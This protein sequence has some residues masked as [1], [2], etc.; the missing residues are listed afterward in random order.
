[1]LVVQDTE[2]EPP[3]PDD[4]LL[5]LV[6]GELDKKRA[7]TAEVYVRSPRFLRIDVTAHLVVTPGESTA[8]AKDAARKRLDAF[9]DPFTWTFGRH[10]YPS[11][12]YHELL[13]LREVAIEAVEYLAIDVEGSPRDTANNKPVELDSDMLVY[14][15]VHTIQA[16]FASEG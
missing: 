5:R 7:L 4:N 3:R 2:R 13:E 16:R 12:F 6:C 10:L 14:P 9:L 15:G 8:D 1:M 11:N